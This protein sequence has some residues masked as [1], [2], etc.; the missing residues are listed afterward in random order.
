[1]PELVGVAQPPLLLV[2]DDDLTYC[3]MRLDETSLAMLRD[4]GI[5]RL[6]DS[7]PRALTWSAAW[8]MTRDGE[9]ATRDYVTMVIAGADRETDIGVMQ[10]LLRQALR[11]LE[12]YADP[13]WA[14]TGYADARRRRR[15]P[16]CAAPSP[17]SDHQLAW[18]HALLGAARSAEHL[19]VRRA[20]CYDGS[21]PIDGLAVDHDLRWALV[22]T[23]VAHRTRRRRRDRARARARPVRRRAAARRDGAAR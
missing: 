10:S 18:A 7:L 2:N 15:W 14:P 20:G 4:G 3:K 16:R 11:A 21:A 17:G 13:Q 9:M 1:M 12:I 19:D 8:D 22:S 5:E 6:A 23:L